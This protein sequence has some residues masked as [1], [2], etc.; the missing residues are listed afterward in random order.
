MNLELRGSPQEQVAAMDRPAQGKDESRWFVVMTQPHKEDLA[1][2]NL[3]NQ[4]FLTFLPR[5]LTTVRHSRRT[6]QKLNPVFPQ[7]LFVS[8]DPAKQRWRA[9]NGTLGVRN[10]LAGPA[11]PLPVR[12]G[13]I[14][15]MLASSDERQVL[16]FHQPGLKPGDKVR[17]I[18]GPFAGMLGSLYSLDA[19]RRVRLLLEIMNGAV[20]ASVEAD[21]VR[22]ETT[23][24]QQAGG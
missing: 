2:Q 17:L 23:S 14:E 19:P 5:Q 1:A 15:T 13:V 3:R 10:L 21:S 24:A 4:S 18:S 9:V 16:K 22:L 12:A 8:L 11:G 6:L 20:L 7:Y